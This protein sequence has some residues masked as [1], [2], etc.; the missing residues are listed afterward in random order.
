[1]RDPERR[2]RLGL[3]MQERVRCYYDLHLVDSAY[4][5]IYRRHMEAPEQQVA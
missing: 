5:R 4:A 2:Q 3:V 1:L